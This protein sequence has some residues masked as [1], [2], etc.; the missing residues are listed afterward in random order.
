MMSARIRY[1]E[2]FLTAKQPWCDWFFDRFWHHDF[3]WHNQIWLKSDVFERCWPFLF[4][5]FQKRLKWTKNMIRE[6]LKNVYITIQNTPSVSFNTYSY[7]F[8]GKKNLVKFMK[9]HFLKMLN[10]RKHWL[11]KYDQYSKWDNQ[12]SFW[13]TDDSKRINKLSSKMKLINMPHFQWFDS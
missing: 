5:L 1:L 2:N 11:W 10:P 3:F 7:C 12:N 8:T 9:Y 4:P 13:L 6:N